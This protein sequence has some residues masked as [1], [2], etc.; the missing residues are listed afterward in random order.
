MVFQWARAT[1]GIGE[2][3]WSMLVSFTLHDGQKAN[4]SLFWVPE[5]SWHRLPPDPPVKG[6][7]PGLPLY[8]Y[9][10]VPGAYSGADRSSR[11]VNAPMTWVLGA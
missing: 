5:M 8:M 9:S 7:G 3:F 11:M 2:K 4:N 10:G 6:L 1:G